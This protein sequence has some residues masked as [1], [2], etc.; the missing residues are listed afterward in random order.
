M[1]TD[2]ALPTCT[3]RLVLDSSLIELPGNTRTMRNGTI[4][5][6]SKPVCLEFVIAFFSFFFSSADDT[7]VFLS[8]SNHVEHVHNTDCSTRA[9]AGYTE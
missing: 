4:Q 1:H 5:L 9:K 2:G 8:A 7:M 6:G 3:T